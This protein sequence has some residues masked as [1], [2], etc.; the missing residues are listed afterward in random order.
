MARWRVLWEPV[1]HQ[2]LD[3]VLPGVG[4]GSRLC[5]TREDAD[6]FV[7][8]LKAEGI[9]VGSHAGEEIFGSELKITIREEE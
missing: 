9:R 5:A 1:W 3:F 8:K 7:T 4:A 2:G 6:A